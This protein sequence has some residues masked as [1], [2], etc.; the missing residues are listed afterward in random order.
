MGKLQGWH[1]IGKG[2]PHTRSSFHHQ[3][4]TLFKGFL[5]GLCHLHLTVAKL[6]IGKG[7]GKESVFSKYRVDGWIWSGGDAVID[8]VEI[9]TRHFR[10]RRSGNCSRLLMLQHQFQKT[11]A[12]QLRH[13]GQR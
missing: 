11:T 10:C 12:L 5:H 8:Q 3:M 4:L 7:M 1:Q 6:K 9:G 2:F 13:P